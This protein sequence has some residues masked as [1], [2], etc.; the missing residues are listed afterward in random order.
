LQQILV[1][2]VNNA[3]KF[4]EKGSVHIHLFCPDRKHWAMEVRD[5]GMGIPEDEQE[6]IFDQF[7]QV[8]NS[9]TRKHAG[10]G[11]G[12]SIVNQLVALMG[13]KVA[14]KSTVGVG[15]V[16]TVTLPILQPGGIQHE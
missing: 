12:L 14:V 6:H 7:H 11:L 13:G 9:M 1:N 4:T 15:S 2:L 10:F 8:D 5:T 16:F 3:L